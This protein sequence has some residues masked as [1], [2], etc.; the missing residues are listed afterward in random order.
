MKNLM[1]TIT[2]FFLCNS[3]LVADDFTLSFEWGDIPLC[4]SGSPNT[5]PNP[6]FELANV[7][8]GTKYIY[9]KMVDKDVPNYNHGGG[10]VNILAK[11]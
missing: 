10:S 8:E 5:V 11:V 9:F 4:T 6:R 1:T 2:A 3:V 7:P